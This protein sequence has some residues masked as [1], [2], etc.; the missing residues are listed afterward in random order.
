MGM[1]TIT[2]RVAFTTDPGATPT[3]TDIS[4]YLKTFTVHRGRSDDQS[5]FNAGQAQITLSN[6]TRAFD[7]TYASSPYYPNVL[8]MRRISI[9]ATYNAITYDVFNGYVTN[10]QQTFSPPGDAECIVTAS[11]AFKVLANVTLPDSPYAA[12]VRA[13]APVHWWRLGEPAGATTALDSIGSTNVPYVGSPTLGSTGLVAHSSLTAAKFPTISDRASGTFG[14]G[15]FPLA[16]AATIEFLYR[17]DNNAAPNGYLFELITTPNV[18]T[19]AAG[20]AVH[21]SGGNLVVDITNNAGTS[22][23]VSSTGVDFTVPNVTHHIAVVIL[24]A[25]AVK[26]YIDGVDRTSGSTTFSGSMADTTNPWLIGINGFSF[27]QY[28]QPGTIGTLDEVALY[29]T[30][31]SAAR[32]SAHYSA[33]TTPWNGDTS[34]A[35]VGRILNAGGWPAADRNIDTGMAVLQAADTASATLLSALQKVEQTEGGALFVTA[36]GLVRFIGHDS[37]L[38]SPYTTPQATFGDTGTDLEYGDL[39]Y[40]YDDVLI[41]NEVRVTRT[42]GVTQ[43][44]A[45]T[46]S[47]THYLRRTKTLDGLL[48]QSD[49]SSLDRANWELTH[50]SSPILRVTGLRLEP[51]ANNDATHYP[52]VLGR[53]LLDRVTVKRTPQNLGSTIQQDVLIQGISHTVTAMEW[54]TDWNLSPA[55]TQVYWI[56]GTA[57]FSE[58]GQTTRLGF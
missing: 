42:G 13:D 10:W 49:S 27:G 53:E 14:A 7:P 23:S 50:Y 9:Q 11:D 37:L 39:T 3:W 16:T 43:I 19:S 44:V 2:V 12:E 45:D 1:P 25:S 56:L 26:I 31:L 24:G 29:T 4:A 20:V 28:S 47:Q 33:A 8:P 21:T 15:G 48:N 34:G 52:Q 22:I 17:L 58:L 38:K 36:A 51:A 18:I 35:R 55:E 46:T 41:F 57:G 32:V 30:A 5:P 6:E 40:E 54:V